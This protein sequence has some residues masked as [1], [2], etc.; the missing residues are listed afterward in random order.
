MEMRKGAIV[1]PLRAISE[2]QGQV[3]VAVVKNGK[4]AYRNVELGPRVGGVAVVESGLV[5]GETIVIDGLQKIRDGSPVLT[6]PS[7]MSI[8][9]LLI[10]K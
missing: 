8:D 4:V 1:I 10:S 2:L 7:G 6:K 5:A 9:S 3:R